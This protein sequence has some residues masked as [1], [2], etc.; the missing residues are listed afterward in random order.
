MIQEKKDV[1]NKIAC[2]CMTLILFIAIFLSVFFMAECAQHEC[3]GE[4]CPVCMQIEAVA[5]FVSNLK[6][7]PLL[8]FVVAILCVFTWFCKSV[9]KTTFTKHTLISLKVELL[10]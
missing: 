6:F 3:A 1:I 7:I 9:T 8:S 10:N 4:N 2:I 5:H